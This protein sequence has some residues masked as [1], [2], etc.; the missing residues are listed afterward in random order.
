M[1]KNIDIL[2]AIHLKYIPLY[3]DYYLFDLSRDIP[4]YCQDIRSSLISITHYPKVYNPL[5]TSK[6]PSLAK[7]SFVP[8]LA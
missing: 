4:L 6:A 8:G 3:R 7:I 1:V 2:V 5:M